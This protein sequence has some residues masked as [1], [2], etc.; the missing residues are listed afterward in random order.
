MRTKRLKI[1]L[2]IVLKSGPRGTEPRPFQ[3]LG[4]CRVTETRTSCGC[5]AT[6][7][8][9][10]CQRWGEG[11]PAKGPLGA[12]KRK[13]TA[14]PGR[15]AAPQTPRLWASEARAA[16]RRCHSN[17]RATVS[18][19]APVQFP[20]ARA[21]AQLCS[22]ETSRTVPSCPCGTQTG[23]SRTAHFIHTYLR[24]STCALVICEWHVMYLAGGQRSHLG[25]ERREWAA[26]GGI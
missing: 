8:G 14:S 11:P 10:R 20:C 9:R 12:R 23:P 16:A 2:P 26:K 1:F 5:I 19:C 4:F 24:D 25:P 18:C 22:P 21:H 13:T 15:T 3:R 7:P 6:D 17:G